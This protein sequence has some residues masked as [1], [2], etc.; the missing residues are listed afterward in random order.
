M[1]F[2]IYYKLL[3]H[4]TANA[5]NAVML[6]F[7]QRW[8]PALW[9]RSCVTRICWLK[10]VRI[11]CTA[12]SFMNLIVYSTA[13]IVAHSVQAQIPLDKRNA[14]VTQPFFIFKF[15]FVTQLGKYLVL[16]VQYNVKFL[17]REVPVTV[18]SAEKKLHYVF[19]A[20]LSMKYTT[21]GQ[22]NQNKV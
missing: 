4:Q 21:R 19:F 11:P 7:V 22:Q 2:S 10:L 8:M 5:I 20:V 1:S 3:A 14:L 9:E 12:F 16:Y 18:T 17:Y 15:S 13:T 6:S